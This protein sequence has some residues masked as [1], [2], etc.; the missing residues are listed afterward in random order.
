MCTLSKSKFKKIIRK[1][2]AIKKKKSKR[3]C[4]FIQGR[5]DTWWHNL[6]NGI[7]PLEIW[8]KKIRLTRDQFFDLAQ[9]LQS[10]ITPD[11]L[12]PNHRSLSADK[13]VALTLYYLKDT[14][15]LIMTANNFGV[16][17]NTASS[18]ISQVCTA[19]CQILSPEYICLPKTCDF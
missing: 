10:Y 4:W 1:S 12:S 14:G 5:S 6:V 19:I 18:I 16:A 9:M 15:S 13:K 3:K 7:S 2:L 17:I 11:P 8:K